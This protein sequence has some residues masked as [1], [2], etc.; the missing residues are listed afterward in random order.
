VL[1]CSMSQQVTI[2]ATQLNEVADLL[3]QAGIALRR[4]SQTTSK[5]NPAST[6]F[7]KPKRIAKDDEWFWTP[8]WQ[9]KEREADEDIANG[10]VYK[11]D[12]AAEAIAGLHRLSQE[13]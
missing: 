3:V 11:F 7:P 10:N 1:S 12:T 2:S 13:Q 6:Y 5:P 8:E 4:V 9:Q